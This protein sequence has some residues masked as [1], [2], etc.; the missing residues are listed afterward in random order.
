MKQSIYGEEMVLK[1]L[2][3]SQCS[4]ASTAFTL[5]LLLLMDST[6]FLT[7]RKKST[8]AVRAPTRFSVLWRVLAVKERPEVWG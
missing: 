7:C 2:T 3:V 4:F 6:H 5:I 1:A 8:A